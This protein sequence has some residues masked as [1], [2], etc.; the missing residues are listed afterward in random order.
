MRVPPLPS[1]I[2]MTT[3]KSD[4]LDFSAIVRPG[5]TVVCSQGLA[6][7]VSLTRR[8]VEQRMRIGRFKMFIGP[9]LSGVFRPEHADAIRFQSYCGTGS[10]AALSIG[11]ALDVVPAH[12]SDFPRFFAQGT[13][14]ADVVLLSVGEPD[15]K[16][17]F[18]L[19]I[20]NDYVVDAARRARVVIAEINHRMP[21]VPGAEL[22]DDVR[23]H[24]LVDEDREPLTM[25]RSGQAGTTEQAI[26]QHVCQ[27]VPDGATLEFGLGLLPDAVMQALAGHRDLGIHT[28]V[29][30]DGIAD[31]IEAG[32]VTN[33]RKPVDHG[34]SV[35]GMLLGS[36]RLLD[37]VDR[38]PLVRLRPATYTHDTATIRSIPNFVAI[39]CALEVDLTGQVNSESLQGRYL[40]AIG[41]QVDFVRGANGSRGGRSIM[42]LPSS[43][44]DGS[45]SRIVPRLPDEVVTTAR[46]DVDVVVTE[47]GVA[48]LRGKSVP[49]RMQAVAAI[50]HPRFREALERGGH[51]LMQACC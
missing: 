11:G 12:Y 17:R 35:A 14:P 50:A 47:H 20:S 29:I 19:G 44:R 25:E 32:A 46:S 51:A 10:N 23:P 8:L 3:C 31:L 21:W 33:A 37:F 24:L 41:G 48:E 38:N 26:A 18:N 45:V 16:G 28:G 2:G 42:I 22:P 36:R 4:D 40:G 34:I 6:E 43:S 9:S 1:I 30:G 39:N 27:L 15:A 7:P 49:E 13:L 5:D